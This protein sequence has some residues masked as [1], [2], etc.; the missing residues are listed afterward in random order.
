M[1]KG[2]PKSGKRAPRGSAGKPGRKKKFV[3]RGRPVTKTVKAAPKKR[4]SKPGKRVA[5]LTGVSEIVQAVVELKKQ[6]KL[7][8]EGQI[9]ALKFQ[10]ASFVDGFR[11]Y[12][13]SQKNSSTADS[14]VIIQNFM[15]SFS[16]AVQVLGITE[17]VLLDAIVDYMDSED[18][19]VEESEEAEDAVVNTPA[20]GAVNLNL[21]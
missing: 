20:N 6:I 5:K 7:V 9:N 1:P 13:E 21:L 14:N 10:Q 17:A 4:G 2:I 3:T 15:Y 18:T 12:F 11:Q 16:N 8:M 19:E